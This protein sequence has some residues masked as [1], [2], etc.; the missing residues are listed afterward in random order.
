MKARMIPLRDTIPS[1]RFPAVTIGLIVVNA[2]VFLFQLGV[3]TRG[4]EAIFYKWGIVPCTFTGTCPTRLRIPGGFLLLP[5]HPDY[6][7]LLSSMFLHGGWMNA[8][9]NLWA[10]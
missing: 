5:R 4:L 1:M 10:V 6:L 9:R 3:G 2:F 7:T 8:I